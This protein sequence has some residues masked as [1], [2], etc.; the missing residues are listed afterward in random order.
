MKT[1]LCLFCVVAAAIPVQAESINVAA[2]SDLSFALQE[3]IQQFE[4][5][6]E[7]QVRLTLGSSGNFYAQILNGAPFD[8][9]LS[10]D[11][12]YPR[13]LE[14]RGYAVPGSTFT[15]GVGR[16]ALWVPSRSPLVPEKLDKL[17]IAAVA[18]DSVKKIAIANPAHAPYGRAAVAALQQAKLYDRVKSKLVLGENISQ[19]AQFV[20]SG[21]ADIG[22]IA[23]SIALSR[24]MRETGRYWMIP[25]SMHPPLEQGAVLLKHAGPAGKN[26]YAWLQRPET[27]RIL[28]KYG[29]GQ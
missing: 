22:I 7:N 14:K 17:G 25:E 12:D 1:L 15:Y 8:V 9:F 16:I 24:P 6:T 10:A 3:I 18:D 27:K 11:M 20:Q 28:E 29:F 19:A 26:F 23:L 5:D 2:A 13:D 4:H 21:A